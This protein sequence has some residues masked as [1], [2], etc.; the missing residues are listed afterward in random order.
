MSETHEAGQLDMLPG[1]RAS[2]AGGRARRGEA[3][4]RR[5][6]EEAPAE[7]DPVARVLVDVPLAHLDRPFDYLVPASMD[8]SAR[9][10][11]RVKVRFAGQDVDG[12]V[13]ERAAGSDHDGRLSPLRRVVSSEQVLTPEV[14]RLTALVA[15]RYAGARADVLR[16]AVPPRHATTEKAER[17]PR[18]APLDSTPEAAVGAWAGHEAAGPFLDHL[19]EGGAPRAVWQCLPGADWSLLVAQAVARTRASGRGALVC[20]PDHRD[21]ARLAAALDDVVGPGQYAVLTA[22]QGP[23][24]RYAAFLAAL[25][26]DVQVVIGT[27]SAAFAPVRDLGLVAMWDDG[28]D[29]HC[30][31][32]APYPHA[33]EV[34][35]M[36]AEVQGCAVLLGGATRTVEAEYLVRTGWAHPIAPSRAVVR[37]Q[38]R[39]DVVAN[40]ERN[41]GARVPGPAMG[42]VRRALDEGPVLV[43]TPRSGYVPHLACERC[44]TPARC[45]ACRGPLQLTDPASPPSC[46]WCGVVDHQWRCSTCGGQGLRAPVLGRDRT[47]EEMGRMFPG[48]TVRSSGGDRIIAAVGEDADIVVATPGAEPPASRGYAAVLLLDTW[49]GLGRPELRSDEE[50]VRRWFNAASLVRPHGRVVAVG[51]PGS[52]MLQSLVRWDPAGFAARELEERVSAH[53]PPAVRMATVSGVPEAVEE[54]LALVTL[55]D[56]AEVLGPVPVERR[57]QDRASAP[58]EP[59]EVR[60]VLRVPRHQGNVLS[61]SLLAMQRLRSARRLAAVRVQVDPHVL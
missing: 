58:E 61:E 5:R 45:G 43:Q 9:P 34:L 24:K 18:P 26:G 27:R 51:D 11:V 7:V 22:D 17:V 39:V 28:D 12:F 25:R 55:P 30:E 19:A 10:G 8:A 52:P 3:E 1:L 14:E 42:L 15:A 49:L 48:H 46:G 13:V 16:L 57:A 59:D 44:R 21:V 37:E 33:R 40:D 41:R 35:L 53:L 38:V 4:M 6:S 31:P 60:V 29:L 56:V 50:V 36:R 20:V 2:V 23:A 47:A 32:R 54:A